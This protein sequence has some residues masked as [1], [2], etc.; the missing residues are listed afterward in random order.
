MIKDGSIKCIDIRLK[1]C[2]LNKHIS[3]SASRPPP[4]CLRSLRQER[5]GTHVCVILD[6]ELSRY[7][8]WT[9]IDEGDLSFPTRVL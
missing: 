4:P 6:V 2:V 5:R 7:D 1:M 3:S 8:G 9:R